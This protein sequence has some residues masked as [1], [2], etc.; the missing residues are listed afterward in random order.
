MSLAVLRL[1]RQGLSKQ[2]CQLDQLCRNTQHPSLDLH[3]YSVCAF[4]A[5][6]ALPTEAKLFTSSIP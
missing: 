1:V 5:E 6:N 2:I 3:L 4:K